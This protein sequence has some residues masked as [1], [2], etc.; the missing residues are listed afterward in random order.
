MQE[1]RIVTLS[2]AYIPKRYL[3]F[4][5]IVQRHGLSL[6]QTFTIPSRKY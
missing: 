5:K 4:Q 1:E 3:E 2:L 6:V